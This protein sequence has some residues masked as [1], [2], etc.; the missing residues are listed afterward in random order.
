MMKSILKY[1][2]AIIL[3]L[4]LSSCFREPLPG[5]GSELEDHCIVL[6]FANLHPSAG[7]KAS[8]RGD[9][10]YNENYVERVD[11]FFY[12]GDATSSNAV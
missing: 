11:C 12:R 6:T 8:I 5:T 7:T 9:N 1:L 3:I 4:V 10:D 2:P